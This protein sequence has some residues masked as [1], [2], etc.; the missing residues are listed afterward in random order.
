MLQKILKPSNIFLIFLVSLNLLPILA[1][2]L[3]NMGLIVPAKIIYFIYSFSCHQIHWRSLHIGEHQCAWCARDMAIWG[4]VLFVA[5]LVKIYRV[6]GLKWYQVIP[7]VVPILLDGGIQGIAS[8]LG[9]SNNFLYVST[10]FMRALTGSIFGAGL[11]LFLM[12]QLVNMEIT[13]DDIGN[14]IKPQ[15]KKSLSNAKVF[16]ISVVLYMLVHIAIIF[17][18]GATATDYRPTDFLDSGHRFEMDY[19][20]GSLTRRENGVCPTTLSANDTSNP[21]ALDCFFR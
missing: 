18:W 6:K 12:P 5:I 2:I 13:V 19:L 11:G 15:I 4:A 16:F 10:N 3:M 7:F 17:V 9:A 8:V 21:L 20:E 1:P 14:K